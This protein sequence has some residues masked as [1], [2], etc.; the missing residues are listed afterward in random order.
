MIRRT[1]S[2]DIDGTHHGGYC[3]GHLG[4]RAAAAEVDP[5]GATTLNSIQSNDHRRGLLVVATKWPKE[6]E[7]H[8]PLWIAALRADGIEVSL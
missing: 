4:G 8:M 7:F 6:E 3:T 5:K 2:G 1:R